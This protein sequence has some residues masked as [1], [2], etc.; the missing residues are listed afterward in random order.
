MCSGY[1][2]MTQNIANM[3][4]YST[5]YCVT[6]EKLISLAEHDWNINENK[7]GLGI[8]WKREKE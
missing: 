3:N 8:L 6:L 5:I 2:T 4:F 1:K 7:Q